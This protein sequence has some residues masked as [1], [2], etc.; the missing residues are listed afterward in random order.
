M[1]KFL[2][3]SAVCLLALNLS[4]ATAQRP[5]STSEPTA[6]P[7]SAVEV[8]KQAKA[9]LSRRDIK[10]ATAK[11]QSVI[12]SAPKTELALQSMIE[13][14]DIQFQQSRWSEANQQ[15]QRAFQ[16]NLK[17]NSTAI[18]AQKSGQSLLNLERPQDALAIVDQALR[19]DFASPG[20]TVSLLR[21][22]LQAVRKTSQSV[23][24]L[25]T[26]VQLHRRVENQSQKDDLRLQALGVAESRLSP[27]QLEDIVRDPGFDLVRPVALFRVGVAKFEQ[28]QLSSARESLSEVVRLAPQTEIGERASEMLSQ[29]EARERV[30]PR[31]VGAILPLSG[32]QARVAQRTLR[33]LQLG[34]GIYGGNRSGYELA[35]IDSAGNA[36]VARRGVETLVS[37]DNVI[38][39]VG[40]MTSREAQAMA[41]KAQEFGIPNFS[42]SQKSGLTQIGDYVFRHALTSETQVKQLVHEAIHN[43]GLKRF[44]IL[45]SNDAY[46]KEFAHLFWDEVVRNGG[47]IRGARSYTP[48]ATDFNSEIRALVGTAQVEARK[49]EYKLRMDEWKKNKTAAQRRNEP[50]D[51]LPPI[52]DFDAV[53]IPDSARALGQ[54]A[55]T[56]AYNEVRDVTLIGPNLWNTQATVERAGKLLKDPIFLDSILIGDPEFQSSSFYKDYISTFGEPP[57]DFDVIAY[58]TGLMIRRALDSGAT[59]RP[60]LQAALLRLGRVMGAF[61]EV[62]MTS[63]REVARPVTILTVSDGR[64]QKASAPRKQN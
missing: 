45:Y 28:G 36:A 41:T 56:L 21:V 13:L 17:S 12:S 53:F 2:R 11:F 52:V 30:N 39:I 40:G 61:G 32:R 27:Q 42:L 64:I 62:T 5:I 18:A 8:F 37:D 54:I 34:L 4:C 55:P 20:T 24:E 7:P 15:Y 25:R 60:E 6:A 9:D 33:G 26:L 58:D 22:R 31:R 51:I 57:D 43:R 49:H 19:F 38:A 63:Q 50:E 1:F 10:A 48:G 23:E 29:M 44:A 46:G 59:T 35:V 47:A 14:G 16:Q 3:I